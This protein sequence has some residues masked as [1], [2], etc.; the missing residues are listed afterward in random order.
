MRHLVGVLKTESLG[1]GG[2]G[3]AHLLDDRLILP[4]RI[5]SQSNTT[6]LIL[7]AMVD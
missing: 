6:S 1:R 3:H 7:P 2:D 4:P 5:N